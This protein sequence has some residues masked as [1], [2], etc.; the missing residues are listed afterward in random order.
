MRGD[1]LRLSDDDLCALSNRGT[2]R[3]A[4]GE[5]DANSLSVTLDE[6]ASGSVRAQWSDGVSCEL[7]SGVG[8]AQGRCSCPADPPCRHLI[9]TVMAY[10]ERAPAAASESAP[11]A[12]P[13]GPR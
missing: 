3:R 11:A 2:V 10:R 1:L 9:R 5:V 12:E 7:P 6:D 4:R 13:A 8:L